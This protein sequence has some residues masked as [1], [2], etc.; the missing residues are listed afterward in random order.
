MK[1]QRGSK[2]RQ[3]TS[4]KQQDQRRERGSA[5]A[6]RAP[7]QPTG[8]LPLPRGV[9]HEI[10]G[11]PAPRTLIEGST[12]PVGSLD[13]CEAVFGSFDPVCGAMLPPRAS[14]PH[15]RATR[16]AAG[17]HSCQG[18][19]LSAVGIRGPRPVCLACLGL[20]RFSALRGEGACGGGGRAEQERRAARARAPRAPGGRGRTKP[21]P[22]ASGQRAALGSPADPQ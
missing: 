3:R 21:S 19:P 17:P 16:V 22:K 12:G 15:K 13:G 14:Q 1:P 6:A 2:D 5:T 7:A 9:P 10:S 8:R 11:A 4:N 18:R 20:F